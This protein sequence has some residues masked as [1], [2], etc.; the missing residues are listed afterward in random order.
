MPLDPFKYIGVLMRRTLKETCA[1]V[2]DWSSFYA[3][4]VRFFIVILTW[5]I[6]WFAFGREIAQEEI[7]VFVSGLFALI[8]AASVAFLINLIFIVPYKITAFHYEKT[9]TLEIENQKL[10]ERLQPCLKSTN[11]YFEKTVHPSSGQVK[12]IVYELFMDIANPQESGCLISNIRAPLLGVKDLLGGFS[13][14]RLRFEND[15]CESS[16]SLNPGE[17]R[18][19]KILQCYKTSGKPLMF[20]IEYFKA[21]GSA[22][23]INDNE[24]GSATIIS[25][26]ITCEQRSAQEWEIHLR[27]MDTIL[28][29]QAYSFDENNKSSPF[30]AIIALDTSI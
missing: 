3:A 18:R 24:V 10:K 19:L 4:S 15:R 26:R 22:M 6:L 13:Q 29:A 17:S 11:I 12:E 9:K 8:V 30:T 27:K 16:L 7:A 25:F 28:E 21:D 5:F 1:I 14:H 20:A 2:C 23:V